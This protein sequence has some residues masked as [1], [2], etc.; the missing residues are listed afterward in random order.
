VL[1][2]LVVVFE[3]AVDGSNSKSGF[4]PEALSALPGKQQA[5]LGVIWPTAQPVALPFFGQLYVSS[6]LKPTVTYI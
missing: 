1:T 2:L 6:M 4:R 5:V 3:R